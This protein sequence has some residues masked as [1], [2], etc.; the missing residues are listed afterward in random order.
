MNKEDTKVFFQSDAHRYIFALTMMDGKS[1]SNYLGITLDM[2]YHK[3]KATKWKNEILSKI[4]P[5]FCK[6]EGAKE[7][8]I[9]LMNLYNTM[10]K[11]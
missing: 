8:Y 7:A 10:I 9:K 6:I 2:Y 3:E 5:E 1:R 11:S 4:N